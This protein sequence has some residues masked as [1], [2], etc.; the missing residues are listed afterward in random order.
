[1]TLAGNEHISNVEALDIAVSLCYYVNSQVTNI[2]DAKECRKK[3][4]VQDVLLDG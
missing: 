1:M 3:I 4:R 2:D